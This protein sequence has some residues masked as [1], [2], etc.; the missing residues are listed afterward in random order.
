M[1]DPYEIL[2]IPPT[3]GDEEIKNAYRALARRYHPD[4]FVGKSDEEAREAA[5]KMKE[6]NEAYNEIARIRTAQTGGAGN[7][8]AELRAMIGAGRYAE[9]EERLDAVLP[10]ESRPAEWHYFKAVL[11][12]RR[13]WTNDALSEIETACRMAPESA[14][15]RGARE[16]FYRQTSGFGADYRNGRPAGQ[17]AATCTVC[18]MCLGMMCMDYCCG[19]MIRCL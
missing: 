3:A 8:Y 18:D 16:A 11:L 2:G 17:N 4:Q 6:I 13:G 12:M 15:Y 9:A 1:R 19:S 7:F 14:E 5:E 10:P